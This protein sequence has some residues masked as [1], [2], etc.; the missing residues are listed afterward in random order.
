M[1]PH[2]RN[3]SGVQPGFASE[4]ASDTDLKPAQKPASDPGAFF[5]VG[6]VLYI[7]FTMVGVFIG[8][9]MLFSSLPIFLGLP[10]VLLL[11]PV[12]PAV[13]EFVQGNAKWSLPN[14]AKNYAVNLLGLL[15]QFLITLTAI[16]G[17]GFLLIGTM[18]GF[19]LVTL[20]IVLLLWIAKFGLGLSIA[21]G[22]G[23]DDWKLMLQL[24]LAFGVGEALWFGMYIYA[25]DSLGEKVSDFFGRLGKALEAF[26]GN[27]KGGK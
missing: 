7:L 24:V 19:C 10:V 25:E 3:K 9:P 11:V 1:E 8:L 26:S 12:F 13:G 20:V 15:L 18:G 14:L 22:L 17:T 6:M 5:A 16:I 27:A 23:P 4:G 2:G 21:G